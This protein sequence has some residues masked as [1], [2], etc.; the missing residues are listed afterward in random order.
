MVRLKDITPRQ[1]KV[2]IYNF[3]SNMVRLKEGLDDIL[4]AFSNISIPIWYD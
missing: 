3:N 1:G 2:V 4:V